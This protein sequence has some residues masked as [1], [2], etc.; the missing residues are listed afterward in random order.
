MFDPNFDWDLFLALQ[1]RANADGLKRDAPGY[2]EDAV[3]AEQKAE[4][5]AGRVLA[6][7]SAEVDQ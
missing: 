6:T 7:A 1:Y 4:L 2:T 5:Y 3:I